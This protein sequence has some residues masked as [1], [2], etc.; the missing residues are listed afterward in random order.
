MMGRLM[1]FL[2]PC[3]RFQLNRF[4]D[5][6]LSSCCGSNWTI[7]RLVRL[8]EQNTE[9]HILSKLINR[10]H[11]LTSVLEMSLLVLEDVWGNVSLLK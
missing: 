6:P 2:E 9:R 7:R 11:Q 8:P 3:E 5:V 4:F 1:K 10:G